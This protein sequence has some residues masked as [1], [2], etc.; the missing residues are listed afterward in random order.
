[1]N[2]LH[3]QH[4]HTRQPSTLMP[5]QRPTTTTSF[6]TEEI[7][8]IRKKFLLLDTNGDGT[9]DVHELDAAL[10]ANGYFLERRSIQEFINSVKTCNSVAGKLTFE[11]FLRIMEMVLASWKSKYAPSF[12][13][14]QIERYRRLFTIIDANGDETIDVHELDTLFKAIG[15]YYSKNEIQDFIDSVQ[16]AGDDNGKLSFLEFLRVLELTAA[17]PPKKITYVTSFSRE[18]VEALRKLFLAVDTNGDGSIDAHEFDKA[19]GRNNDKAKAQ[20]LINLVQLPDSRDGKLD[21]R[22]FLLLMEVLE[23]SRK[24]NDDGVGSCCCS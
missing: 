18:K 23:A 16:L 21:F 4:P 10:K 3:P 12:S 5:Q 15:L 8:E 13:E 11:E 20:E 19:F 7:R 24:S 6:S 2:R 14:E 22:E 9:I 1:M 17:A